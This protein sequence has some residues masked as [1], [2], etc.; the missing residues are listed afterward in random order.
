M[1]D[2]TERQIVLQQR[3]RQFLVHSFLY[4]K[5]DETTISDHQY[6]Q[7]CQDLQNL[8]SE[9]ERRNED[10]SIAHLKL[11]Q[12]LGKEASGFSIKNYPPEIISAAMHLLFQSYDSDQISFEDFVIRHGYRLD[13]IPLKAV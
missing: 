1:T 6:D 3:I 10:S 7:I 4:Y 12:Q 13:P 9:S 5:L 8:L 11:V 2:S